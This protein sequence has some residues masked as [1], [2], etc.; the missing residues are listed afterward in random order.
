MSLMPAHAVFGEHVV[1]FGAG[2]R[3]VGVLCRPGPDVRARRTVVVLL[4]AGA[5]HRVG[6]QRLWVS[7][8]RRLAAQGFTVFRFDLGGLGD[9][10]AADDAAGFD[11]S[12]Q[13]DLDAALSWLATETH[14]ERFALLGLC[15][16]TLTAFQAAQR[17]GRVAAL[18]LLTALL[19][20]PATVP[21]DVVAEATGRRVSRSY[22]TEKA[23]SGRAWG[24]LLSGRASPRRILRSLASTARAAWFPAPLMPGPA[25]V[26][27]GLQRL[28]D[29]GV[30][31]LFLFAEPSTVLEY[32]RM[33]LAGRLRTLNRH[34][35]ITHVVLTGADHTFTER[36]FQERV[37]TLTS[38]WLEQRC[39]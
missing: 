8:S 31:V 26:C 14:H 29:R 25:A 9:S 19:E 15:S 34:E 30:P 33:T 1:T 13:A 5:V 10:I 7:L 3:L 32:F 17:D 2:G 22:V 12:S 37:M 11:H 38:E 18:L 16:G 20:D 6:P 24:R 27:A 39:T 28:L 21:A 23:L 36:R 35:L 4:N